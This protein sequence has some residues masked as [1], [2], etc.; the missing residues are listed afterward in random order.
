MRY[1]LGISESGSATNF[2]T[3]LSFAPGEETFIVM[4]YNIDTNEIR[5]WGNPDP[6]NF[7]GASAPATQDLYQASGSTAANLGRFILR[8][9]STGETPDTNFDELR[10][11][12][13]WAQVTP[14][15]ATASVG[16]NTITGFGAYP[17]PVKLS[18]IHI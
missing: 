12:T 2:N 13:T 5:V 3:T 15:N 10:I 6:A 17:N 1:E 14:K 7:E 16:D 4:E 11:G 18:L 9:D 8:Q